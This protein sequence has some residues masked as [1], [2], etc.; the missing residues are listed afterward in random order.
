MTTSEIW[1][2][3][4]GYEGLYQV[5]NFGRI[6]SLTRQVENGKGLYVRNGQEMKQAYSSTGYKIVALC[7][8]GK[9]K[10]FKVHRLVAIAFIDNPL[11]KKEVNHIDGNIENNLM[12][13]LEWVTHRENIIHAYIHSS[14]LLMCTLAKSMVKQITLNTNVVI[15]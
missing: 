4:K 7:K 14:S 1:K 5:S 9:R 10:M 15:T 13:N 3:I 8:D 6:R 12:E 2:D 11:N